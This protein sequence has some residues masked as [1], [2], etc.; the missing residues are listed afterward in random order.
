[1]FGQIFVEMFDPREKKHNIYFYILLLLFI[2]AFFVFFDVRVLNIWF[3]SWLIHGDKFT[4]YLGA[5]A[6][7]SESFSNDYGLVHSLGSIEHIVYLD[8]I[9]FFGI[10]VKLFFFNRYVFSFNNIV[11]KN[12]II[13]W[14]L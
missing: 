12:I 3:T 9:P 8:I 4:A 7:L 14:M 1:M 2:G 6:Y 11:N 10:V 13:L 5:R